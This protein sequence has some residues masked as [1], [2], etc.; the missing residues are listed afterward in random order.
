M[1]QQLTHIAPLCSSATLGT[2]H[3]LAVYYLYLLFWIISKHIFESGPGV[4]QWLR[5]CATS[6]TVPGST[7]DGV[8]WDS[9]RGSF[10]Q[11]HVVWGRLGLWKWVPGISLGV[12]ADGAFGWQPTTLVVPKVEKVWGL[13]L[14]GTPRATSACRGITLLYLSSKVDLESKD[15]IDEAQGRMK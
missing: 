7:P 4:A 2:E 12:K 15:Q 14:P 1:L 13:N 5:H 11:N 9:F 6:R 8:T 10:R 3:W